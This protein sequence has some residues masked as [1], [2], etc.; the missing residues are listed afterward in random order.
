M[1]LTNVTSS[2][3][4]AGDANISI[5]AYSSK[6]IDEKK[7]EIE[8]S[9]NNGILKRLLDDNVLIIAQKPIGTKYLLPS[10]K[11]KIKAWQDKCLF[12]KIESESQS[13]VNLDLDNDESNLE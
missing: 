1:F 9:L 11:A 12:P 10:V 3:V 5:G 2:I 6:Y 4:C 7:G 13:L 8:K